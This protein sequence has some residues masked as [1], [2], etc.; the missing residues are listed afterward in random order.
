[1]PEK[2][3]LYNI[4]II[5]ASLLSGFFVFF[6]IADGD[7]FWHLASGREI[8]Q[9]RHFLMTDPFSYTT[10]TIQWIDLHWLFQVVTYLIYTL[11]GYYGLLVFKSAIIALS[12][13]ILLSSS[14]TLKSTI[15]TSLLFLFYIYQFRYLVPMRP[16]I[17][18]LCYLSFFIFFLEN[19]TNDFNVKYLLP[20]I[21]LQILWV[22]TQGLFMIGPAIFFLYMVGIVTDSVICT[23]SFRLSISS[24]MKTKNIY[25]MIITFLLLCLSGLITPYGLKGFL[26]P[27]RLFK[28]ITPGEENLYSNLI[29]ENTPLLKMIGTDQEFYV[30][31][32]AILFT[33]SLASIC[34]AGKKTRSS[35]LF[36]FLIFSFLACMA[37]RNLILLLFATIPLIKSNIGH[38]KFKTA[39]PFKQPLLY[40]SIALISLYFTFVTA[41]HFLMVKSVNNPISPFC[42]PVK[43]TEYLKSHTVNGTLFNADRYGGYLLW[44]LYPSYKVFID[45]RLSMRDRSFFSDYIKLL[46][47]PDQFDNVLHEHNISA[48]IIPAYIPL[49][50]KMVRYFYNNP[51]WALVIADGSEALFIRRDQNPEKEIDIGNNVA[52]LSL[53]DRIKSDTDY[54]STQIKNEAAAR[55]KKFILSLGYNPPVVHSFK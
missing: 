11:S 21:P 9:N 20:L 36:L 13:F 28:Q 15:F 8:F 22:N 55:L 51:E 48:A 25:L 35:H 24:I 16:G 40:C 39:L 4:I 17:L 5:A 44:H 26:F 29:A 14:R 27:F 30:I 54:A 50:Q 18:T 2:A 49:Y 32:F 46:N 12:V 23:G 45:T 52:L 10:P 41:N 34:I 43:S 19:L 33:I 37:Q 31:L 42:H 47:T 6:P 3:P 53:F 7:I 38:F 1:M